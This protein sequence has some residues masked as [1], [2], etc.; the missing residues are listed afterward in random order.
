MRAGCTE[1]FVYA[2][3]VVVQVIVLCLR[4]ALCWGLCVCE[5]CVV[6]FVV[7]LSCIWSVVCWEM[8]VDLCG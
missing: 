4:G 7:V 6:V 2:G 1:R 5:S 3:C 8:C